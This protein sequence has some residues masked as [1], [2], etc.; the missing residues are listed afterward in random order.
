VTSCLEVAEINSHM[1]SEQITNPVG[2][3]SMIL[4]VRGLRVMLDSDLATI[5]GVTT[6]RLKEQFKRNIK[7]FPIDFAFVLT[8]QELADLRSQIATSSSHGGTRY[9][10]IAFTEHGAIMLASVLNS[11]RA[12]EMSLF[13][14][15]AFVCMREQ[16]AANKELARKVAELEG[17]VGGHDEALKDLFEAIR[18]LIEPPAEK[19]HREIGFHIRE[20]APPYRVRTRKRF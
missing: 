9:L 8:R 19:K 10:P 3:E 7:R 15:R 13:V 11:E 4:T 12:V 2:I 14:V 17:R 18:Q 6:K 16:L 1:T 20:T 5:Y